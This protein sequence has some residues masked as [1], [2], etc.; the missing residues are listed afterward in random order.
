MG[1]VGTLMIERRAQ[2]TEY[3]LERYC[4]ESAT[5]HSRKEPAQNWEGSVI[6]KMTIRPKVLV[7]YEHKHCLPQG[8]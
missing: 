1:K 2:V 4:P 6:D 3:T 5:Y 7:G 8:Q